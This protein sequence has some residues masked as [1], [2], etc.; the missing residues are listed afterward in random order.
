MANK[1]AAQLAFEGTF[2]IYSKKA[3]SECTFRLN[4]IGR[5]RFGHLSTLAF[6]QKNEKQIMIQLAEKGR[7]EFSQDVHGVGCIQRWL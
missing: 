4:E 6:R 5:V 1:Q 3:Y 7:S 2:R